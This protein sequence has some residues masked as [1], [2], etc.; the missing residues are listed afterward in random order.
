MRVLKH[1]CTANH[2]KGEWHFSLLDPGKPAPRLEHRGWGGTV[3]SN[4]SHERV[5]RGG[6]SIEPARCLGTAPC[7]PH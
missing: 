7:G 1:V 3:G 5:T 2:G 6:S 4:L